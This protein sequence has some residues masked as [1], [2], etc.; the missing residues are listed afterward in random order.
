LVSAAIF[1]ANEKHMVLKCAQEGEVNTSDLADPLDHG[2]YDVTAKDA[3]KCREFS[4]MA[5]LP[6]VDT[7]F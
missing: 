7:T 4:K 3:R 1:A 6:L 5:A 2:H